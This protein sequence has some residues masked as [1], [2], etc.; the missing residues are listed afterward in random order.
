MPL[1]CMASIGRL[2]SKAEISFQGEIRSLPLLRMEALFSKR[3]PISALQIVTK[4]T[5]KFWLVGNVFLW[6]RPR[7][8]EDS[9]EPC[10]SSAWW[11][12]VK[13][14]RVFH[15][16]ALYTKDLEHPGSN[17]KFV[18]RTRRQE[19]R[20]NIIFCHKGYKGRP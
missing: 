10:W 15:R 16:G 19:W 5:F 14:G 13:V 7:S 18:L 9:N 3:M 20:K 4:I 6:Y 17:N 12:K 2:Y 1:H 8:R 11:Q